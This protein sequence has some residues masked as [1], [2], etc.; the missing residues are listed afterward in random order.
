MK[1]KQIQP[2]VY[3]V[4][5]ILTKIRRGKTDFGSMKKLYRKVISQ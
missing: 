2:P 4:E 5:K 1:E 3:D